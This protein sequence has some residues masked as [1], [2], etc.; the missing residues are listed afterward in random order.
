[1]DQVKFV[2]AFHRPRQADQII[3]YFLKAVFQKIYLIHS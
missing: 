2:D 3:P 1:M